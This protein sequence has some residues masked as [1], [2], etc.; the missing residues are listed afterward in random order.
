MG[1]A[2]TLEQ[3][4]ARLEAIVRDLEGD[5]LE[6]EQALALFEEGITQVRETERLLRESQLRIERLIA[7]D[8]GRV[9][10]QP[11]PDTE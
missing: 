9:T 7:D 4:M 8:R 6:L 3:R 5:R 2:P 1:D 10:V 11:I